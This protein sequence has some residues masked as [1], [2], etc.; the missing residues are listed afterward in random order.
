MQIMDKTAPIICAECMD[1]EIR[2][3]YLYCPKRKRTIYNAKPDW[4]PHPTWIDKEQYKQISLFDI[5]R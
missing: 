3:G 4:C 2:G 1:A 5:L